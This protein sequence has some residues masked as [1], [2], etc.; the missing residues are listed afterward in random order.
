MVW[1]I[2]ASCDGDSR[3]KFDHFIKDLFGGKNE[4]YPVPNTIGKIEHAM[5]TEHTVYDFMFEVRL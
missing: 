5:P 2:G 3:S 4:H 1:S